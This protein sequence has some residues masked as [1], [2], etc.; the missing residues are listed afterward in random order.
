MSYL[1]WLFHQFGSPD[2]VAQYH[3]W[4]DGLVKPFFAPPAYVFGIAWGIVYPLI[5]IGFV[6]S[7]LRLRKHCVPLGFVL[8]FILNI[9]LNLTFTPTLIVTKD[10]ALISLHIILVLGTLAWLMLWA[11]KTARSV[12]W[13]LVPYLLWAT[14]ATI[15]QI[16]LTAL[17]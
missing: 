2:S 6:Q 3:L 12:F 5:A 11:R 15:L 9:A 17:N 13:L 4:Y 7:L 14:F 16:S 1:Y 10:N 8:L